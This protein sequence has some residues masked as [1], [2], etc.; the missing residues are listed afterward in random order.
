[1]NIFN[2]LKSDE[3]HLKEQLWDVTNNYPEWTQERVFEAVKN[4]IDSIH[5]HINKK[6]DMVLNVVKG[7]GRMTEVMAKWEEQTGNINEL[8]NSLIMIHVDEP[9]FESL[10]IKLSQMIDN[11]IRFSREE[12]YPAV[13]EVASEEEV[14]QM[15]KLMEQKVYS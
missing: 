3:K 5:A 7:R 1:M 8:I 6:N 11:L 9:G 15:G 12:L 14:K 10:L 4:A 13:Q 2:Y